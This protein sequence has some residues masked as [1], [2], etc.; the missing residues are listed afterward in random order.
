M[1]IGVGNQ[2]HLV[3]RL[4][5]PVIDHKSAEINVIVG[6]GRPVDNQA[7]KYPHTILRRIMAVVPGSAVLCEL[8]GIS[9]G[10]ARCQRAYGEVS[11]T[12]YK[13]TSVR[14]TFS[15]PRNAIH[16]NGV[17]LSHAMPMNTCPVI[18]HRVPDGHGQCITPVF[19]I[20][21]YP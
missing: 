1:Q 18:L 5:V 9:L 17:Q 13:N 12:D 16:P 3:G 19:A 7:P 11:G 10:L 6:R 15:N 20:L 4:E 21:A 8:E 14:R 2:V